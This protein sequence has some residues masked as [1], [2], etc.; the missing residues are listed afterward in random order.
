MEFLLN[1]V[2][3]RE[4][5]RIEKLNEKACKDMNNYVPKRAT[6]S[7]FLTNSK[8]S[9]K[10]PCLFCEETGH[11]PDQ[12]SKSLADR[13]EITK[14]KGACFVCLRKG[15]QAKDCRKPPPHCRVS[16]CKGRHHSAVCGMFADIFT[17]NHH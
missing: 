1:E 6:A 13:L 9:P 4:R 10:Y 11:Y 16:H 3:G 15:H 2:E 7:A 12:C 14:S 8:N 17:K 5:S